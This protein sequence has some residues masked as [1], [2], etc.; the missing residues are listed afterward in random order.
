MKPQLNTVLYKNIPPF[1]YQIHVIYVKHC[2]TLWTLQS[3][4]QKY[5]RYMLNWIFMKT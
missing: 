1:Y 3:H 2:F 4:W 5:V